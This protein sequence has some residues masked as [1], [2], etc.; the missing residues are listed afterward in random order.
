MVVVEFFFIFF[1]DTFF[2][3]SRASFLKTPL[4]SPPRQ[5]KTRPYPSPSFPHRSQNEP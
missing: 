5:N 4:P 1:V 3:F 2:H